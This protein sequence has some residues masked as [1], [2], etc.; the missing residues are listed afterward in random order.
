MAI[1]HS[2]T[3]APSAEIHESVVIWA[4]THVRENAR[5]GEGTSL[6]QYA[7]VGPGAAIGSNCKIQNGALIYEPASV[8]NGVFIGPRVIFTNDRNP[9]AINPDGSPKGSSDWEAVGVE[10]M[11]GAAIGAGA[12]CVAPI[13]IGRW[14]SVAAGAVVTKDVPDYA[15]VAGVPARQ[16]GWVGRSGRF[17][18]KS[19]TGWFCPDTGDIFIEAGDGLSI[20]IAPE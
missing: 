16:L 4:G 10:V 17:L 2:A 18:Q 5:I 7:Y 15:L 8:G 1:H 9:R 13:R 19:A 3:V 11:D 6:G 14:A 12:I 20:S